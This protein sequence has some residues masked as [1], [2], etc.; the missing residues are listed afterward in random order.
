MK[1]DPPGALA[2]LLKTDPALCQQLQEAIQ[3][4]SSQPEEKAPKKASGCQSELDPVLSEQLQVAFA[5]FGLPLTPQEKRPA[6][7]RRIDQVTIDTRAA[8]PTAEPTAAEWTAADVESCVARVLKKLERPRKAAERLIGELL[9]EL[10][11]PQPWVTFRSSKGKLFFLNPVSRSTTWRHPL[12]PALQE[13]AVLCKSLLELDDAWRSQLLSG[14]RETIDQEEQKQLSSWELTSSGL[15]QH[16]SGDTTS[17]DP[18]H[19]IS[20]SSQLKRLALSKLQNPRYLAE[21]LLMEPPALPAPK[22]EHMDP[23]YISKAIQWFINSIDDDSSCTPTPPQTGRSQVG[24]PTVASEAAPSRPTPQGPPTNTAGSQSPEGDD[25]SS[26]P[27]VDEVADLHM[28]DMPTASDG[29]MTFC[30]ERNA[31]AKTV[32]EGLVEAVDGRGNAVECVETV[33]EAEPVEDAKAP[34]VEAEEPSIATVEDAAPA[35]EEKPRKA[36]EDLRSEASAR[37]VQQLA[38]VVDTAGQGHTDQS[39]SSGGAETAEAA[40]AAAIAVGT[41]EAGEASASSAASGLAQLLQQVSEI[42][43]KQGASDKKASAGEAGGAPEAKEEIQSSEAV[44]PGA[45]HASGASG[46]GSSAGAVPVEAATSRAMPAQASQ[47]QA[48][49]KVEEVEG[50]CPGGEIPKKVSQPQ[51][52]PTAANSESKLELQVK[53]SLGDFDPTDPNKEERVVDYVIQH[54]RLLDAEKTGRI[55]PGKLCM[56]FELLGMNVYDLTQAIAASKHGQD[57]TVD[58]AAFVRWLMTSEA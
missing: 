47:G 14:Q 12:E 17:T 56:F 36:S 21:L 1:S 16:V 8:S 42:L 50:N 53:R 52:G 11:L 54:L 15:W 19:E 35:G 3:S 49:L 23:T 22:K 24:V 37:L 39:Q 30:L 25:S 28:A 27:K 40:E 7:E 4:F 45:I 18:S 57:G 46:A 55:S 41:G 31:D 33:R 43:A 10:S 13:M 44:D 32:P 58:Y 26:D 6:S 51:P 48:P 29:L 34:V 9:P 20:A 5:S 2:T 38:P